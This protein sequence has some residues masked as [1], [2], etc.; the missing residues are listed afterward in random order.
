MHLELSEPTDRTRVLVVEDDEIQAHILQASLTTAE[1]EVD[2]VTNGLAAV[3]IVAERHYDAVLVDYNIPEID[4]LA[5]ARLLGDLLGPIARPLLIALTATPEQ[6]TAREGSAESAFDLILDKSADLSE[7][8]AA[9][10]HGVE[11]APDIAAKHAARDSIYD[12]AEED[13]VTGQGR[14]GAEGDD[15]GPI[16]ILVVEDDENQRSLLT[17]ILE[18]KGYVVETASDGLEAIRRIRENCCD[19]ALVDYDLPEIDGMAVAT[20]VHDQ[21]AQAWRPRLVALTA[22]PDLLY[23]KT[24]VTGPLFDRIVDKSSG[25]HELMT[26]IDHLLRFSPNPETRRAAAR[27]LPS[28][29]KPAAFPL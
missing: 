21:M 19:L 26:S 5:T 17:T 24:A 2:I 25:L 14:L 3:G 18:R 22:M 9:I 29:L 10:A 15:P 7:I 12:K 11:T 23:V 16:R 8:I 13:Y 28:E 6:I 1:F 27:V 20:L 4:G